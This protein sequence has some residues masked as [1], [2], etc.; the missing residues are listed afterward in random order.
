MDFG[1]ALGDLETASDI[2]REY[3]RDLRANWR[4]NEHSLRIIMFY[5]LVLVGI[6]LLLSTKSSAGITFLGIEVTDLDLVRSLIPAVMA[7]FIYAASNTVAAI[8]RF[9]DVHE[10]LTVHYWPEF[11]RERLDLTVVPV[12]SILMETELVTNAIGNKVLGGLAGL[13]GVTR[14]ATTALA[15]VAFEAYALWQ[16]ISHRQGILWLDY[17][18]L[19]FVCTMIVACVPNYVYIISN[20]K[21]SSIL[22]AR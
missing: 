9:A 4:E 7:Y 20:T 8:R 5:A 21:M 6:F 12:G 13:A 11:Y 17:V 1:Q 19:A 16:L 10:Q 2:I 18:V 15:P 14:F 3:Q 22:R